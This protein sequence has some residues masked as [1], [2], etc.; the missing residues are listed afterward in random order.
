MR[1]VPE[2]ALEF[3]KAHEGLVL[4]VYDDAHP[5]VVLKPGAEPEGTFTAGYGHTGPELHPG[6]T[7]SR[8]QAEIWLG[9]DAEQAAMRL[10]ARV[11]KVVDELTE[12]QYAALISFVFN[13]GASPNWTIWKRLKARQFDQVPL[14]MMRFV[15]A[16]GRKLQ[17]LVNRRAAE[18]A[19]WS[20]AEP[21]SIDATPPSSATRAGETPPTPADPVPA[22]RSGAL[23]TALTSAVAAVSVAAQQMIAAVAPFVAQSTFVRQ[24]AALLATAAAAAA[25]CV[26]ALTWLKKLEA[27]L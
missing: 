16:G 9:R 15:N 14:E 8:E 23:M 20:T 7:V 21:G 12:Q 10:T 17:G 25:V 4:R 5:N 27:R 1:P 22:N 3:L 18:V 26:L 2:R 13:L 19:V 11:G 24:A 6:M